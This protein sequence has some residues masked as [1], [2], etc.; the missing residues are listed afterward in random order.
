[1]SDNAEF[2]R[3]R[4]AYLAIAKR[5]R[6]RPQAPS[7]GFGNIQL[8]EKEILDQ[9]RLESEASEYAKRFLEE[10]DRRTFHIGVSNFATNRAFVYTI[11]AAKLLCGT[12]ASLPLVRKLLEMALD[13]V[14]QTDRA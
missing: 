7:D 2:D 5:V 1:M 3:I 12:T 9:A 13:D 6:Y 14:K 8:T 10:E 11:E 4:E